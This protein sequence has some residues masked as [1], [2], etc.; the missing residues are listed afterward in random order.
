[1]INPL[2]LKKGP[3]CALRLFAALGLSSCSQPLCAVDEKAPLCN[4]VYYATDTKVITASCS[5][6]GLDSRSD[7]SLTI[8][9]DFH[10]PGGQP[11]LLAP[12]A[13]GAPKV[14]LQT[15]REEILIAPENVLTSS[16]QLHLSV[17]VKA[18]QL[19]IGELRVRVVVSEDGTLQASASAVCAVT[20]SPRLAEAIEVPRTPHPRVPEIAGLTG[21]QIGTVLGTPSRLMLVE[22]FVNIASGLEQRWAEL[23]GA[24]GGSIVRDTSNPTWVMTIQ[25]QLQ[26]SNTALF[27]VTRDALLIYDLYVGGPARD[28][29]LFALNPPS[30]TRASNLTSSEPPIRTDRTSLAAASDDQLMLLGSSDRVSWFR[31]VPTAPKPVTWL[32]DAAVTGTPVLAARA[33]RAASPKVAYGPYFGVAWGTDGKATLLRAN[34]QT[35]DLAAEPLDGTAQQGFEASLKS[36]QVV[37][38]ALADLNGDGLE[39]LLVATS[40]SRFLWAPQQLDNRFGAVRELNVKPAGIVSALSVGDLNGDGVADLAAIA[41]QKA[42]VYFGSAM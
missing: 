6:G 36:E 2:N 19:G 24:A 12:P 7:G 31:V 38:A 37:A 30:P 42:F 20:R 18:G 26:E 17:V 33:E 3:A 23:Y 27:A 25:K 16:D 32:N 35:K 4:P 5:E 41:A 21:V 8:A 15:D 40:G 11:R 28:L 9:V 13:T 14:Y 1:M 22:Q 29:S 34:V 39:D 10:P